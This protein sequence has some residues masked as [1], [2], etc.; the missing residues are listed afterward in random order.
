M[1]R[2]ERLYSI[3]DITTQIDSRLS[4]NEELR[5]FNFVIDCIHEAL[6]RYHASYFQEMNTTTKD[7]SLVE[8]QVH[9]RAKDSKYYG[10]KKTIMVWFTFT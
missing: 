3:A 7:K 1:A 9:I 10:K 8:K 4:V 5:I 6:G 2:S